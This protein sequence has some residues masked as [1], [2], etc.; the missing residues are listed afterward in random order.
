MVFAYSMPRLL[1]V[2]IVFVSVFAAAQAVTW[3]DYER[4]SNLRRKYEGLVIGEA[5]LVTFIANTSQFWY[6]RSVQGGNEFILADAKTAEKKPAFDHTRLANAMS[7]AANGKFT[8]LTLP[9]ATF[10]FVDDQKAIT[11]TAR[12]SDWRCELADYSCK[13]TATSP[14]GLT[15]PGAPEVDVNG[16]EPPSE[17]AN[18]VEDGMQAA[19]Q[20]PQQGR[21]GA[22]RGGAPSPTMRV[23]PD[24]KWEAVIRNFNVAVRAAGSSDGAPLSTALST[25]LSTDGSEGNYYTLQSIAWSP[26]SSHLVAYRVRPGYH[27]E[28]HYIRS[29]PEDQL[30][31]K[32]ESTTTLN[33]NARDYA[34]P[35]D[36]LD[37][38]QPVLFDVASKRQFVIDNHLFPK[39]LQLV[40]NGMAQEQQGF[41]V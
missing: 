14:A 5:G 18:E 4:A 37:I 40:A 32:L 12:G 30:Q 39:S 27:R 9:F 13:K 10:S 15:R 38:A 1:R 35:G 34:K 19:Q 28:I 3:N 33:P 16:N 11:F 23:S 25:A 29:S 8:A 31:P 21:G 41:Y 7:A 20:F 36:A 17:G 26:D 22:G 24:G 6:R 2:A